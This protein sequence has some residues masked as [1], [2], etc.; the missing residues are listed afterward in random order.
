MN[1]KMRRILAGIALALLAADPP[2]PARYLL[3][4]T[5]QLIAGDIERVGNNFLVRRDGGETS[6]PANRV[7]FIGKDSAEIFRYLSERTDPKDANAQIKLAQWCQSN[8]LTQEAITAAR[9]AVELRPNH[10]GSIRMLKYC[11]E[12][13]SA[14]KAVSA[15][16]PAQPALLPESV[17]CSPEC[18]QQFRTKVQP[19]LMNACAQCH[20]TSA[21]FP[22][23]RVHSDT[24]NRIATFQNLSA[25][26]AQVDRARPAS[27]ALL[28]KALTAHGGSPTPPLRDRGN[29]AYLQLDQWVR[30]LAT[31]SGAVAVAPPSD[32][33]PSSPP[34]NATGF[35][36]ARGEE[37][38][39]G[40][41]DPFDP[42]EFNKSQTPPKPVKD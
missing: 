14:P 39:T 26:M 30:M 23:Q 22:L 27:S 3:L 24:L 41:K 19:V 11:E 25:A 5:R 38:P 40:P 13:A 12:M 15:A 29:A 37:K 16:R 42:I 4:D 10:A 34:A 31:D 9:H 2:A 33:T 17:D 20:G 35:A 6:I 36:G 7:V 28:L 18:L 21:K 8:E 1:A 32:A